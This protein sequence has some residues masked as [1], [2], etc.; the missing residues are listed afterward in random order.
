V[1][2]NAALQADT[3]ARRFRKD[4]RRKLATAKQELREITAPLAL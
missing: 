4:K 1:I 2:A 3:C